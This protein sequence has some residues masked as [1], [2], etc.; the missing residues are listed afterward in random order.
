MWISFKYERLPNLCYWCGR[1]THDDRDCE[2]LLKVEQREFGPQLRATPFVVARKNAISIPGYYAAKKKMSSG[3]SADRDSDRNS[4]SGRGKMPEQSQ[5]VTVGNEDRIEGDINA[6]SIRIKVD[7]IRKEAMVLKDRVN[8]ESTVELKT[9]N[10]TKSVLEANNE[11][12]CL[13][14]EFG[15]ATL[16]GSGK[17]TPKNPSSCDN[18]SDSS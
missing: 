18:L 7:K 3:S 11:K 2:G 8:E 6:S 1:L 12:V 4:G 16:L 5:S 10:Q 15:A 14:K 9:P 13:A 17:R